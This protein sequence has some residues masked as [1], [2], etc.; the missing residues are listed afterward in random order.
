M[1]RFYLHIRT[2]DDLEED[3]D[4]VE[5]PDVAA[6]REEALRSAREIVADSIRSAKEDA[7]DC[8]IVADANGRELA[9]VPLRD[10]LPRNLRE[11]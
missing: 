2:G 5:L 4:G 9:T 1:A 8:F 6:A 3:P 10:V 11:K 7:P